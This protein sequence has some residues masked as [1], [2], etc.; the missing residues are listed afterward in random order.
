[1]KDKF[2][3]SEYITREKIIFN[4]LKFKIKDKNEKKEN[5]YF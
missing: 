2:S 4:F 5:K 3:N 1:M